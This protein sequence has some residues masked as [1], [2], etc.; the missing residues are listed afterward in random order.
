M[1]GADVPGAK[2]SLEDPNVI[3]FVAVE[4]RGDVLLV[5]VEGRHWDGSDERLFQLQEKINTYASFAL[6]GQLH[7]KYPE[8][9]GRQVC[10]ELRCVDR[11]DPKTSGFLDSVS[12]KLEAEGLGFRIKLIGPVPS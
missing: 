12:E 6:D 8:M 1:S 3:D 9:T 10:I 11:P 7:K 4:E 2:M 5:M